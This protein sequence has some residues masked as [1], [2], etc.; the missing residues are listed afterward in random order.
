MLRMLSM[1]LHAIA[2]AFRSHHALALENLA[3]RQQLAVLQRNARRPRLKRWDRVFWVLVS[4]LW[5]GWQKTLVVVQPE[6]VIRW[7]RQGFRLYWRRKSRPCRPGR[8][9]VTSEIRALIRRMLM[10][11]PFW[12]GASDSWRVAEAGDRHRSDERLEVHGLSSQ[13]AIADLAHVSG[14]SCQGHRVDRFLNGPNG[15]V[16]GAV[17]LPCPEQ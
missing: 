10:A 5:S 8:P 4:R 6:T 14:E 15:D 7:H 11:S 17:C 9:R 2:T 1:I 13:T 16:S 3:L 12:G